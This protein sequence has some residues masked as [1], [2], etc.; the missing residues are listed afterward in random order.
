MQHDPQSPTFAA[1]GGPVT[2]EKNAWL[3]G[4]SVILPNVLVREG[5]VVASGAIVTKSTEEYTMV[6]GVP[7]KKIGERNRDLSYRLGES[8]ATPF[9]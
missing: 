9:I 1:V 2:I 5:T 6:G 8:G 3:S 7:A 4:R